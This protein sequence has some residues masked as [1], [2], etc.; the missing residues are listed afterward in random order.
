[1]NP[2]D[3]NKV[4]APFRAERVGHRVAKSVRDDLFRNVLTADKERIVA[5]VGPA[6][7]GKS[8]VV[9]NVRSMLIDHF[10]DQMEKDPGFLP[11]IYLSAKTG[12][13]G[14]FNWKDLN[15]RALQATN[16]PLIQRK[17]AFPKFRLDGQEIHTTRNLVNYELGRALASTVKHRGVRAVFFDEASAMIA[18][19]V[20]KDIVLQ[21]NILKSTAVEMGIVIVMIGAYDLLGLN[22]GNGQILRRAKIIHMPRYVFGGRT[23]PE[24]DEDEDEDKDE[25]KDCDLN[26]FADAAEEL[27]DSA[28]IAIDDD[29]LSDWQYIFAKSV[30]CFGNFRDW[31]DRACAAAIMADA[32]SLTRKVF[33]RESMSNSDVIRLTQE[34]VLGE[35]A[36]VDEQD[37]ELAKLLGIRSLR[38]PIPD[39]PP[40][41]A[42]RVDT[43]DTEAASTLGVDSLQSPVEESRDEGQK[44]PKAESKPK[45]KAKP[46]GT[47]RV[48][49]RGPSRDRVGAL[50][51]Q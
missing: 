16:E 51:A 26:A 23:L 27:A 29:V 40:V 17:T 43:P 3:V 28:P 22:E 15:A 32:P 46:K 1:V 14:D 9:E 13:G 8:A 11:F 35:A 49:Q 19:A 6:G 31:L 47:R 4:M 33:E 42:T 7:V 21:F 5:L 2:D 37:S 45:P 39:P 25:D 41:E 10:R 20:N 48:G 36:M 18:A 34:A 12:Y 24:S 30:G 50:H 38:T 44:K